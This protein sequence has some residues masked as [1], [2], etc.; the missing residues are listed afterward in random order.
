MFTGE[1]LTTQAPG[2][3]AVRQ[4]QPRPLMPIEAVMWRVDRTEDEILLLIESGVLT[5]TFDIA[6]AQAKRKDL[7]MLTLEIQELALFGRCSQRRWEDVLPF[8]VPL[9]RASLAPAEVARL[10]GCSHGH[11]MH[12]VEGRNFRLT[13]PGYRRGPG[14]AAGIAVQ[15]LAEWL[16]ERQ[17]RP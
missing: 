12:L 10:L 3:A 11:V 14:G 17:V 7:R 1:S 4:L 9:H 2:S 5:W 15:S 16:R 6:T 13:T 8:L